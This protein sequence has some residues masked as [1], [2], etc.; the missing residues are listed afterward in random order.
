[1]SR[2]LRIAGWALLINVCSY[3]VPLALAW[4]WLHKEQAALMASGDPMA[5]SRD[6]SPILA[7]MG[8]AVAWTAVLAIVNVLAAFV[9]L[10]VWW[11]R[12]KVRRMAM[13]R[14]G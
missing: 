13:K 6:T 14:I 8:S 12:S 4:H 5:F 2:R 7:L 11:H 10:G 1:M 9:W 3:A